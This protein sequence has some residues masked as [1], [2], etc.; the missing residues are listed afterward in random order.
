MKGSRWTKAL[1]SRSRV[2]MRDQNSVSPVHRQVARLVDCRRSEVRAGRGDLGSQVGAVLAA[3]QVDA[4]V[5]GYAWGVGSPGEA[6][7]T[8]ETAIAVDIAPDHRRVGAPPARI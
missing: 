4:P 3:P 2:Q 7:R 8:V 5:F 6:S 1:A